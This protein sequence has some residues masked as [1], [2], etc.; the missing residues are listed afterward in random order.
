MNQ[1]ERTP[2]YV[3]GCMHPI[4]KHLIWAAKARSDDDTRY[5]LQ[6]IRVV[7][8]GMMTKVMATDGRRAHVAVF[9]AGLFDDDVDEKLPDDGLYEVVTGNKKQITL[10]EN[11]LDKNSYPHV[12]RLFDT[13]EATAYSDAVNENTASKI[14]MR[15]HV[16]L[17]GNFLKDACA[18]GLLD[19]SE[20]YIKHGPSKATH[21]II[22]HDLGTAIVM[23]IMWDQESE[24]EEDATGEMEEIVGEQQQDEPDDLELEPEPEPEPKPAKKKAKKKSAK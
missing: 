4:F 23:P 11:E 19:G 15:S 22:R 20:C 6:G 8:D 1:F 24:S 14:C 3:Y 9:D 10:I 13:D 16:L 7:R 18:F 17:A 5:V 2:A 12:E 21:Y